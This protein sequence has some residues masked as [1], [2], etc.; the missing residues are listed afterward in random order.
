MWSSIIWGKLVPTR[1]K[2][3]LRCIS[4]EIVIILY[5]ANI[6][7][8][9]S[10][11]C[12][13]HEIIASFGFEI[14][15]WINTLRDGGR[16]KTGVFPLWPFYRNYFNFV[17]SSV[18]HYALVAIML[19]AGLNHIISSSPYRYPGLSL[20]H[21]KHNPLLFSLLRAHSLPNDS[22]LPSETADKFVHKY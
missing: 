12:T 22:I 17:A 13:T 14:K 8:V 4:N 6:S 15:Y 2:Y 20:S 5:H 16:L 7:L 11:Y 18:S 21:N 3:S 19:N 10:C 1:C 9:Y